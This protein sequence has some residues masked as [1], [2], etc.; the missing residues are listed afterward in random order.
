MFLSS[1]QDKKVQSAY[2]KGCDEGYWQGKKELEGKMHKLES[3]IVSLRTQVSLADEEIN[4][5]VKS[6]EDHINLLGRL[7]TSL[8][9]NPHQL[10]EETREI[11][12]G[13]RSQG[14]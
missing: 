6:A 14:Q 11:L 10:T 13:V 8:V 4:R 9:K 3:E 7:V 1:R 2:R 5:R 12:E